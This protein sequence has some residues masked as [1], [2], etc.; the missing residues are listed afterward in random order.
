MIIDLGEGHELNMDI[1]NNA[2][3]GKWFVGK[4]TVEDLTWLH[5]VADFFNIDFDSLFGGPVIDIEPVSSGLHQ[6]TYINGKTVLVNVAME[7]DVLRARM[8]RHIRNV[9]ALGYEAVRSAEYHMPI[10]VISEA[11]R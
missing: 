4:Y 9:A 11:L 10:N 2:L 8:E 3:R 5:N 7:V 6:V 1:V